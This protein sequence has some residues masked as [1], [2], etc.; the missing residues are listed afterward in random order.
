MFL[1]NEFQSQEGAGGPQKTDRR[2]L[3]DQHMT[4]VQVRIIA[5]ER[6]RW[7]PSKLPM[8]KSTSETMI[9]N[10]ID[11]VWNHVM[12]VIPRG[13]KSSSCLLLGRQLL[14]QILE[15]FVG[16]SQNFKSMKWVVKLKCV[17]KNGI[18]VKK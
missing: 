11:E 1:R 10:T 9:E 14:L 3:D 6:I 4:S 2:L 5:G 16:N 12:D 15:S 7:R 17:N 18:Q 13:H 8:P